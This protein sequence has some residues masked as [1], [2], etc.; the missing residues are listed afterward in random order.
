M[1]DVKS[2]DL[3][4]TYRFLSMEHYSEDGSVGRP[5]GDE[6]EGFMTYTPEGY[7]MALL[8]RSDRVPFA[9]GDI[10]GGTQTEQV[11]AFMTASSFAGRYEVR[12]GQI[13]HH[14]EAASFPNW[15]GTTQP[16]DFE[17][18]TTQL[19][20]YPPALL[21]DAQ[22]RTSRVVLARLSHW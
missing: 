1:T 5:F 4:G 2:S 16:R 7:M 13:H 18:T 14:L 9:G 20:L 22:L 6:P 21:M 19:K 12:D 11:S 17:L 15:K 3:V 10:L 8:S